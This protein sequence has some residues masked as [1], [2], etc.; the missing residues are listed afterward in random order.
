MTEETTTAR[1]PDI[2][3]SQL[4]ATALAAITAAFL[5]SRL[6]TAGTIIGAGMASIVS[7]VAG[8]LYQHSLDHRS[9]RVRMAAMVTVATFVIGM[10]AVTGFELLNHGPIS[11]GDN[12]TTVGSLFGQSTVRPKSHPPTTQVDPPTTTTVPA[13]TTQPPTTTPSPTTT[14][15]PPTSTTTPSTTTTTTTTTTPGN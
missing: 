7:T 2:K 8:A 15:A 13:T 5:G 12:G 4:I 14:T 11:G 10:A 1:K 6:G 9:N 3:L